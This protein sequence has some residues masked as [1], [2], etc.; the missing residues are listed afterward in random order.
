[1]GT[2]PG[3]GPGRSLDAFGP[4][5]AEGRASVLAALGRELETAG[6]SRAERLLTARGEL[7]EHSFGVMKA[8]VRDEAP[9]MAAWR[10]YTG[11]VWAHL[12][13]ASLSE[14]ERRRLWVPSAVYGLTTG[15]DAVADHRLSFGVRLAGLGRLAGF[16]RPALTNAVARRAKGRT[17]V[18]LL[19]GEHAAALDLDLLGEQLEV[20]RVRFVRPDGRGAAGHGAKAV[21]GRVARQILTSGLQSLHGFRWEG[22]QVRSAGGEFEVVAPVTSTGLAARRR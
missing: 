12:E 13:P 19:P 22:W 1:V 4:L 10:R 7:L 9:T 16:W 21:K 20:V 14:Q 3:K 8:L 17:V 11:V 2:E 15:T 6:R 18:D 5:L